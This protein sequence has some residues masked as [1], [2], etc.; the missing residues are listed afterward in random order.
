AKG[1]LAAVAAGTIGGARFN[2]PALP[3]FS[4]WGKIERV[5]MRGVRRK[6]TEHL[7]EAWNTI[8]HVTQQDKA[9]ITEL[10]QLRARFAP[11]A[12]EAGGKI[13]IT[14]IALKCA[15]E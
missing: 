3:D 12:A 1:L 2:E 11:K 15:A 8:P 5:F 10:E 6:T 4:K 13:T 7:R 14:A 9:D